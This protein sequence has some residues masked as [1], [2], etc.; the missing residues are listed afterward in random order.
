MAAEEDTDSSALPVETNADEQVSQAH[1][2]P[3]KDESWKKGPAWE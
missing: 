3:L 2:N 1:S